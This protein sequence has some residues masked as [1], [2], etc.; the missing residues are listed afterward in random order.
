MMINKSVDIIDDPSP[1]STDR[2]S[3]SCEIAYLMSA[4]YSYRQA[5][6]IIQDALDNPEVDECL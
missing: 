3:V 4:G 2:K 6:E 5:L 1:D